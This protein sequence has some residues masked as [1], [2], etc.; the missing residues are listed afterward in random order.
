MPYYNCL[1]K[2]YNQQLKKSPGTCVT[3]V[4]WGRSE[5]CC[6]LTL[7]VVV[8]EVMNT[9]IKKFILGVDPGL[10]GAFGIIDHE[11]G[12][13]VQIIDLKA[14]K[15]GNRNDIDL[16]DLSWMFSAY[17]ADIELAVVEDVGA[18]TGREGVSSMF[19][20]GRSMGIAVGIIA[21]YQIPI[22]FVIP[23]VW[24]GVLGLSRDKNLSRSKAAEL[25][26]LS[27]ADFSLK[28]HCDRAEAVLLAHFG[29]RFLNKGDQT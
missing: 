27:A 1:R 23:S 29:K 19:T 13:V 12:H 18:M 16:R 3:C 22:Y 20:F 6:C 10:T 28:K 9:P 17:A 5:F 21:A 7:F 15:R 25:F 8:S 11:S 26:P 4:T 14:I 2:Y 24:K